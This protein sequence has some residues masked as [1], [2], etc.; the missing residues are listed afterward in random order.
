MTTTYADII[1]AAD[2]LADYIRTTPVLESDALNDRLGCR[3]LVKAESLQ[4]TGS[5]KFRGAF[6]K[7]S[8]ISK[9]QRANGIVAYSSGNHA[10]GVALAA[11]LLGVSASIVMPSDA[12]AIKIENTKRHGAEVILYER[13]DGNRVEVAS[14]I[15]AQTGGTMVPPFD[16]T[17]IIAGQGTIGLE[18]ARQTRELDTALDILIAPS[19]GGGMISGCAIALKELSPDTQVYCVEPENYDDIAR[20]LDAG[21]KVTIH[22]GSSSICDALLIETPGNITFEIMKDHLTGGLAVSDQEALAAM[23]TA[24]HEFKLVLEPSGATSLAAVLNSNVDCQG[25]TVGIVC[26]GGNVDASTFQRALDT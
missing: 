14:E 15:L 17:E 9:A 8:Q 21:E 23:K 13:K 24:F 6:N 5:F 11:R 18:F 7:I 12:P 25:K 4:R 10:Q 3:L 22:P 1:D 26:S 20:S 2:R 16:D 19:S